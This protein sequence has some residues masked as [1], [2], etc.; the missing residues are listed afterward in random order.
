MALEPA[1]MKGL[2]EETFSRCCEYVYAGDYSDPCPLPEPQEND[3]LQPEDPEDHETQC[4]QGEKLWDPSSL[5]WNIFHPKG[6]S[7]NYD[8]LLAKLGHTM[9]PEPKKDFNND[10]NTSYA[11]VFLS[12]AEIHRFAARTGWLSLNVLS[13]YRLLRLLENFTLFEERV[14]DIVQLLVFTFEE[15]EHLVNLENML[16]DYMVWNVEVLMRN[17]DF[18]SFLERNSSLEQ[19]VFRSMWK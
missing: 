1:M 19:T 5:D 8:I 11:A 7:L 18:K 4:H 2:D 17:A 15:S 3:I 14:D 10:P 9:R 6:L 12:H 13:F 16:R